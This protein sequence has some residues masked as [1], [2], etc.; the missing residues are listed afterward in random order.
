MTSLQNRL[1]S[2]RKRLRGLRWLFSESDVEKGPYKEQLDV[3]AEL[4]TLVDAWEPFATRL[5]TLATA[6][7]AV[8]K[9][10]P[11]ARHADDLLQ[12][13]EIATTDHVRPLIDDMVQTEAAL[14]GWPA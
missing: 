1:E 11:L 10:P 3:L 8:T 2:V 7:S 4:R 6:R 13:H 14:L 12:G 5:A 9:D